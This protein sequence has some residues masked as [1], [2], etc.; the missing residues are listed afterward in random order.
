MS[1]FLDGGLAIGN[2]GEALPCERYHLIVTL[3]VRGVTVLV[4]LGQ[5]H[6]GPDHRSRNR[7]ADFE[8]ESEREKDHVRDLRL[9]PRLDPGHAAL[10][11]SLRATER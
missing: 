11:P 5:P 7:A 4:P 8:R 6:D 2:G 3:F 10:A 1:E 9:A